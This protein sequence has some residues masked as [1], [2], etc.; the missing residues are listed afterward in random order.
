MR[1]W[2]QFRTETA[3]K[4]FTRNQFNELLARE[5]AQIDEPL[6]SD[7]LTGIPERWRANGGFERFLADCPHCFLSSPV[8]RL[9]KSNPRLPLMAANVVAALHPQYQP[10]LVADVRNAVNESGTAKITIQ[11]LNKHSVPCPVG[12]WTP[13]SLKDFCCVNNIKKQV[14]TFYGEAVR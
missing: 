11:L 13:D 9:V 7:V 10:A 14:L 3:A 2:E 8:W 6:F 12:K 5:Q 1:Q 4:Q